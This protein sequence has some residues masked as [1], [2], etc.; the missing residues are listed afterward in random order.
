MAEPMFFARIW[1]FGCAF[2]F[3][4]WTLVGVLL[5]V[6]PMIERL[7]KDSWKRNY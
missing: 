5:A 4:W 3:Q 7:A 6:E 1:D 2:L